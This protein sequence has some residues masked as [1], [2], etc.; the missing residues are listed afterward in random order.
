[1]VGLSQK[2]SDSVATDQK[3]LLDQKGQFDA[4]VDAFERAESWKSRRQILSI[5][6]NTH[7]LAEIKVTLPSVMLSQFTQARKRAEQCGYGADIPSQKIT[8]PRTAKEQVEYFLAFVTRSHNMQDLPFG[9]TQLKLCYRMET[10]SA[11]RKKSQP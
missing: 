1:M 9:E 7:T 8:R 6:A 10:R 3:G 11:Y 4:L 5:M 2:L